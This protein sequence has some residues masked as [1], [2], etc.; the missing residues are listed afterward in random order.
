M[1]HVPMN[2][3]TQT[4]NWKYPLESAILIYVVRRYILHYVL[5]NLLPIDGEKVKDV[6]SRSK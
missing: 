3:N 2:V 4:L 1:F 5:M 6:E